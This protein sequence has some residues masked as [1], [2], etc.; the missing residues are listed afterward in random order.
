MKN[1]LYTIVLFGLLSCSSEDVMILEPSLEWELGRNDFEMLVDGLSRH[2]AIHVPSSYDGESRV[3]VLFMLHGSGGSGNGFYNT[4]KW[5]EK[6]EEIGFI[7]VFPSALRYD[8][9]D[10]TSSTKWSSA[11]LIDQVVEG[12]NIIDDV[13]F[14]EQIVSEIKANF[15]VN[16][17]RF[18]ITGFSNGSGFVKS[19]IIQ[20]MGD[21]FAAANITGGVGI[22]E[23]FEI[24]G[25]RTMPLYN[26]SG[27]QDPRIFESIGS[28]EELPLAA[29]DIEAHDFL[30]T[31]LTIMCSILGLDNEY[32]VFPNE[33]LWNE[34]VFTNPSSDQ[35][36]PEYRF[37]MVK[38]MVHVYPSGDNNPN[39][40]IAA[41]LLWAWF[42]QWTL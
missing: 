40:L 19:S 12:T 31:Q 39:G 42:E 34:M 14:I 17:S 23:V 6:S 22:P 38:D 36:C 16:E 33:P 5:V 21:V 3:P 25:D 20:R 7:A 9:A 32:E 41:D 35:A 18:Y 11:S 29:S 1:I 10:G 15:I 27:S 2:V 37:M 13:L 24:Q 8:L 28:N 26:I 30:W 4:S